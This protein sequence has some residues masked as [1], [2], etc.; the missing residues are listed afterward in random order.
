[1]ECLLKLS[2]VPLHLYQ[3]IAGFKLLQQDKQIELKMERLK[4]NSPD[5]L[6]YNML[7][8]F[9]N[10]KRVIFDM[11]DGYDNLLKPGEDYL[12]LYNGI[13]ERCDLLYKRSYNAGLNNRLNHPEKIRKTAPNFLVTIKGSPAHWPVPCDPRK[14]KVKKVIRLLP[15]TQ[16]YNG[17][18]YENNFAAEPVIHREL[19]ILFMARLW[20]PAGDYKGQ[21]SEEKSEERR[22][23]NESRAKCI[24][25]CRKEFGS[26]FLGGISYSEF[27]ERE[28]SD[29]LLDNENISKK[30]VYLGMVKKSDIH[31]ATAGLHKSTGWKFAEYIA[32]SKAIVSEPLF[33]SSAGGLSDG[34]HYLSFRDEQ[35]CCERI[36]DLFDEQRRFTMMRANKEYYEEHMRCVKI[37]GHALEIK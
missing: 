12:E 27:A 37:A 14:E 32:A 16:Y 21:L 30:S 2:E 9:Y 26:R 29:L 20:D 7:E 11:N 36:Q 4:P 8:V 19:K 25:R 6:P 17:D 28:Y 34:V 13:L 35:E 5:R 23:I 3:I 15:F 24:R 22:A 31:I 18:C 1:M 33:Y 10:N